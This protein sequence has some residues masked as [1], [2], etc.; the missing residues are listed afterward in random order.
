M[1]R[2]KWIH[3]TETAATTNELEANHLYYFL[4]QYHQ[5]YGPRDSVDNMPRPKADVFVF[6]EARGPSFSYGMGDHHILL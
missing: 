5:G 1:F 4:S 3:T 2:T 6:A